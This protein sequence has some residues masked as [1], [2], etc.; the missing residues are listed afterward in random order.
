MP[1]LADVE[2]SSRADLKKIGGRL[3]WEDESTTAL[4]VVL[5]DTETGV[6]EIWKAGDSMPEL[7]RYALETGTQYAAHN[8]QG[9]DRFAFWRLG[10]S[11]PAR[12]ERTSW[13]D[14]S[15]LAR[16][17]GLP[18]G[19]DALAQRWLGL[20]KDKDGSRFTVGLSSARRP[21]AKT[22]ARAPGLEPI[23]AAEWSALSGQEKKRRGVLPEC[24]PEEMARVVAYCG[25]DVDV[26]EYGWPLLEGWQD[27]EPAVQRADR[28]VNDRGFCFD[29]QLAR[30]L[31]EEDARNGEIA[32]ARTA[33]ICGLTAERVRQI[34]RSDS[35]FPEFTGLPNAQKA[36]LE[37][38]LKGLGY[39]LSSQ[40]RAMCVARDALASIARGK[41]EAGLLRVSPDGRLRDSLRYLGGHTGR[42]SGRGLQPQNFPRP[43]KR[44]EAAEEDDILALIDYVL[45][46]GHLD[47][48][49]IDILL[50]ACI[51]ASP[52]NVLV[53]RDFSGV[54]ARALAWCANDH[55]ALSVFADPKRNAYKE[56]AHAIFGC[57][58]DIGK[59]DPLYTA[60]KVAELAC[61]GPDTLVLTERG[62][63]VITAVCLNDRL[64]D[65]TE[66][67]NHRGLVDR[68][69]RMTVEC[70]GAAMTPDHL[71]WL[72]G[73]S[74]FPAG[75]LVRSESIRYR[76]L[77]IASENYPSPGGYSSK[78]AACGLLPCSVIAELPSTQ[79]RTTISCKGARHAAMHARRRH[80]GA[81]LKS[82][83]DMRPS[84]RTMRIAGGYA[85]GY[86]PF[87]IGAITQKLRN[88]KTTEAAEFVCSSRGVE[89]A[90]RFLRILS[91]SKAGIGRSSN[92][93]A[94]TTIE[95]TSPGICVSFRS[96][97][98][99]IT[100][101]L[102]AKCKSE[103]PRSSRVYDLAYAGPRNRFTI[104]TDAGPLIVHNCGYQGG[105]GA[106]ERMGSNYG[107]SFEAA[108]VDPQNVVDGWR[109]LHAP[110]V[111]FWYDLQ[112]A[113]EG[114]AQGRETSVD[115]FTFQPSSTGTDVAVFLPS[116]RPLVYNDVRLTRGDRGRTR[117]TYHG[118]KAV[119]EDTYGG[120][121]TENLIQALCRDLMA[122]ALA[123]S[124]SAGLNP[125]LH[126]H[127]EIVVDCPRSE[128][129]EAEQEL[130]RIMT[131]VPDWAATFPIGA[132]GHV[133]ERYRK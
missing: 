93:I 90:L 122:D 89:I 30:R 91:R 70:C 124:D 76:A 73:E 132:A 9:F 18:G 100:G 72:G 116:G 17:A 74:W 25:T 14:T 6:R 129:R 44:L 75:T 21:T 105:V 40:G 50:R 103:L 68:G 107:F 66:W 54:E 86:P 29:V 16:A 5:H 111:R 69:T 20:A 7:V 56:A 3:Y 28:A 60:G 110:T 43:S 15:E 101:A 71:C 2:S 10:W 27:L 31:L 63:R 1:I 118:Q 83:T 92:S 62:P 130:H 108:G 121:I 85:A 42:W 23:D 19:L 102:F 128:A 115:C 37:E 131:S 120:K 58:T 125:V 45:G 78:P 36:T 94:K 46:G 51:T 119:R 24:G 84:S 109:K 82:G 113:F 47:P 52:G 97:K 65:G 12:D 61:L 59:G 22:A 133:G 123:R 53:V 114:A 32:C 64:W 80:R 87:S 48:D 13:V 41:L 106:L 112:R 79:P 11:T 67:V 88:S 77:E 39:A 4:C 95:A 33:K 96:E 34:A 81:G 49:E 126:V 26:L 57:G 117:I 104:L 55:Q 8:S 127:D 38:A 98:T 35:Q 99:S